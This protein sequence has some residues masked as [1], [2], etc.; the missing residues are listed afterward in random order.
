MSIR[1]QLNLLISAIL[2]SF[3]VAIVVYVSALI[4]TRNIQSERGSL[5]TVSKSLARLRLDLALSSCKPLQA[6]LEA[7]RASRSA[8]ESSFNSIQNLKYLK[9]TN[10]A[11]QVSIVS[12]QSQQLLLSL[13]LDEFESRINGL[14]ERVSPLFSDPG[15]ITSRGI[16]DL[17]LTPTDKDIRDA[18]SIA[19]DLGLFIDEIDNLDQN[20][21]GVVS[22]IDQQFAVISKEISKLEASSML[23]SFALMAA[24]IIA[25]II[26]GLVI[27]AKIHTSFKGIED[28]IRIMETGDLSSDFSFSGKSEISH[29]SARLNDFLKNLRAV[30]LQLKDVLR[31]NEEIKNNLIE[32]AG[33]SSA[34]LEE[35]RASISAVESKITI[36][37]DKIAA[38]T[39]SS[40]RIAS[41]VHE[42]DS[43]LADLSTMVEETSASIV[44]MIASIGNVAKIAVDR[45]KSA[46]EL[47]KTAVAGGDQLAA[48]AQTIQDVDANLDDVNEIVQVIMN[49][50]TQTNL[51]AM[52]AAIEAA[53]AGDAGRGFSVV[54]EEIRNL[55]EAVNEQSKNI[56]VNIENIVTMIKAASS[57]SST[58]L[59]A[60][61]VINDGI[62]KM[63]TSLSEI[64]NTMTEI[65]SGGMQINE[66]VT[67]LRDISIQAKEASREIAESSR[68][69]SE[70]SKAEI[71]ISNFVRSSM[72]DILASSHSISQ[73][74]EKTVEY[75]KVMSVATEE[76]K[77]RIAFFKTSEASA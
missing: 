45:R 2:F 46:G 50:S 55:A 16:Y 19:Y 41:S 26:L 36:L 49:I 12:I 28:H 72:A 15:S 76:M 35:M 22:V 38:S 54:A 74:A 20:L 66:A 73:V 77:Q 48:M 47:V 24:I 29:L 42:L 70:A 63:D 13:T 31:R 25:G 18:E 62:V 61:K 59:E 60:F 14:L 30:I 23:T 9:K 21:G 17:L 27:S 52:N 8:V 64:S 39:A 68:E 65:N 69:S 11:V 75:S 10:K 34:S 7:I 5:E 44:E 67:R 6:Q 33:H 37:D 56:K 43:L 1:L 71:E 58:T 51:L 53:H 40:G 57:E 3:F 32:V 4:P